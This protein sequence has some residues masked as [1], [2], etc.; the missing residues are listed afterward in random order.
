MVF[1]GGCVR[2]AL[3]G[4][5][6]VDWDI[7]T[8]AAPETTLDLFPTAVPIGLRHGTVMIPTSAGPVDVTQFRAGGSLADDLAHRDFT[9]NAIAWDPA[10]GDRVDPWG[11]EHDL[12]AG[13][14][15]AVGDPGARFAEDPL[16]ALRAVRLGACLELDLAPGLLEAVTR[17]APLLRGVAVE[18]IRRELVG[19]LLATGVRRGMDWLRA[20]GI[21]AELARGVHPGAG[22][23]LERLP[24]ELVVR[25]SGWLRG[26]DP[27]AVLG[28]LRFSESLIAKVARRVARHPIDGEALA[29][30]AAARRLLARAGGDAVHDLLRLRGA[31]LELCGT[32]AERARLGELRALIERALR[33]PG[34][35]LRR[36]DLA[37]S[38]HDV[39]Q[40][41]GL[42]P[43]RAVGAALDYLLERVLQ[44]PARNTRDQ[45]REDLLAWRREAC[46]GGSCP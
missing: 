39:M 23:L 36:R 28:P 11:G 2:D 37:L 41:T 35:A 40:I 31:E 15:R 4:A 14:L 45:L 19:T 26:I 24:R 3:R 1:V 29:G 7:A 22:A 10:T 9:L 6:V 32:D 30:E 43:G 5:P 38:G 12:H 34:L 20:S 18:R 16:R 25:L 17:A 44:D 21:E 8:S 13:I 33:P 27:Q 42:A 46:A